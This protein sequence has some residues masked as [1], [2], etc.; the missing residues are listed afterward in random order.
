MAIQ[1]AVTHRT[2]YKYDRPVALGPQLIRLRPAS[3]TR[4]PVLNYSLKLSPA[5]H[6]STGNKTLWQ[7]LGTCACN[8]DTDELTI[9]VDL[10]VELSPINPFNFF[11]EPGAE[12]FPFIT[13]RNWR[14]IWI[15]FSSSLPQDPCWTVSSRDI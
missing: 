8:R 3:H 6:L 13:G 1:V 15:C 14:E 12:E 9:D 4:T 10:L 11:I 2:E 7:S 5:E